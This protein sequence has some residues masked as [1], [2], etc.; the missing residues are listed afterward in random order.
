MDVDENDKNIT[1]INLP[2]PFTIHHQTITFQQLDV[3]LQYLY[4]PYRTLTPATA[5]YKLFLS[6]FILIVPFY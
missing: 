2:T 4:Q 3:F 1:R 6:P 5:V